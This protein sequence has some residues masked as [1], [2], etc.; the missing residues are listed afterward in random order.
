MIVIS[1]NGKLEAAELEYK[2]M[3]SNPRLQKTR[4]GREARYRLV[5]LMILRGNSAGAS[6]TTGSGSPTSS[7]PLHRCGLKA[8]PAG[9]R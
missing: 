3:L 1:L 7:T 4:P 2:S 8:V 6:S 5:E 9:M